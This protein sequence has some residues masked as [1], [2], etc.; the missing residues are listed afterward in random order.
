MVFND[1]YKKELI[2]LRNEGAEFCKKNPGLSSYLAKEGQDP[3]VERLL[4]GFAFLSGRL[5]QQLDQE[6]PEVA[7]TLVQLLWPNYTRVIPSYSIIKYES[8][9]ES[10][11]NALIKRGTEVLSKI[12]PDAIQCKFRTTYDITIMPIGLDSVNYFIYGKKSSLELNMKVTN[13]ST[14]Q[15]IVFEK[16]RIY[17]SGSKFISQDLYLFLSKYIEKIEISIKD[18][19]FEELFLFEID[20]DSINPVGFNSMETM[21]SYPANIFDGYILL[22]EFFCFKEKYLFI[23]IDNLSKINLLDENILSKSRM[24]SIKIDFSKSL[25]SHELPTKD[26]FSLYCTPIINLFETDAVPIRKNVEQEEFLVLPSD[27]DKNHSE[28]FSVEKVRGWSFKKSTYQDYLPFESFEH[29]DEENE[30]YSLRTKLSIDADRTNT[31]LR[32]SGLKK[33]ELLSNTNS[34]ISIKILCT[35]RNVPSSLMLGDICVANSSSNGVAIPFKNITIPTISYPPPISGDFLWRTISNMSLNYLSLSDIKSLR[36]IL[37]TYDFLGAYDIRQ[38][39]KTIMILKGLEN[40]SYETCEIIDKGLPIRGT[41]IK[42][43]INSSKFSCMG[44]VFIFCSILNQFFS[45]YSSINSFHKLSIDIQNEELFEW[46]AKIGSQTL[47]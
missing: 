29:S 19:D 15:N 44:E 33:E 26:N 21:T 41:H 38:K 32:F 46:P 47:L 45:L 17:L 25:S 7:H 34:T 16:L 43:L 13:S 28:V 42:L 3:D 4:E 23:D 27:L 30:Y 18:E 31:Y 1:Y 36:M 20:K 39:E 5:H 10:N 35:N 14:L 9:R 22:Q 8:V 37:E 6:L 11:Q 24:F 2:S 40:I 12:K